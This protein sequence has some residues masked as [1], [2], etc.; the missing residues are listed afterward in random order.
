MGI[1]DDI[2]ATKRDEVTLLHQPQTRNAIRRAAVEALPTRDFAGSLRRPD[3]HLAVVAEIKRRSPSKGDLDPDLDPSKRAS[4]FESGGASALSVLTDGPYFGGR[5]QDLT[6]TR[7]A[8]A[9]PILRKDF[10]IAEI[11]LFEARALGADAVLLIVAALDDATLRDLREAATD[12]GLA[13]LVETH[14]EAEIERAL[15]AGA[16]IVGINNRSLQSFSEDLGIAERLGSLLPTEVIR[17]GESA[18]RTVADAQ[19]MADAGLDA[20]LVGEAF[21]RCPDPAALC[22]QM[23]AA[24]VAKS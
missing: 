22:A 21:S 9:L 4:D 16:R 10:V 13:A 1:L 11:Q 8:V 17:I 23:A 14:D 7:E 3:G 20:V 15:S 18:V 24:F 19:R 6:L 5:A 12:L 2:L